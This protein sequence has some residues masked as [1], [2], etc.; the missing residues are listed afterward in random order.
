MLQWQSFWNFT[1]Q[2]S[3]RVLYARMEMKEG[4]IVSQIGSNNLTTGLK[5]RNSI[6][7]QVKEWENVDGGRSDL[8]RNRVLL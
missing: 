1:V 8:Q 7:G 4:K 6:W 2:P 3:M 5:D